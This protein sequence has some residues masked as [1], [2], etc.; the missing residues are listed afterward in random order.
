MSREV[1][2]HG[3]LDVHAEC[4]IFCG[5][6]YVVLDPHVGAIDEWSGKILSTSEPP[7]GA[8]VDDNKGKS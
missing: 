7:V 5:I 3:I 6:L 1:T 2:D 4:G 8:I